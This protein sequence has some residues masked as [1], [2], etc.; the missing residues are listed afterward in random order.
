[1]EWMKE[2]PWM[3]FFLAVGI[4]NTI[5][6]IVRGSQMEKMAKDIAKLKMQCNAKEPNG[7]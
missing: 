4:I 6:S 5:G 7:N 2:H 3:T 1:M